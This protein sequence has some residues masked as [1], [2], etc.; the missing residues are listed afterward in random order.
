VVRFDKH[1][2]DGERRI[3]GLSSSREA[4]NMR[5]YRRRLAAGEVVLP[6]RM[7]SPFVL[8]LLESKRLSAC[9]RHLA[10]VHVYDLPVPSAYIPFAR[11]RG[12]VPANV[13]VEPF[14]YGPEPPV[15]PYYYG[16]PRV[17]DR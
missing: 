12:L 11:P 14:D 10:R 3:G 2:P 13:E 1:L 7:K 9:W 17:W 5:R 16:S 6:V 8:T 4:V 15:R